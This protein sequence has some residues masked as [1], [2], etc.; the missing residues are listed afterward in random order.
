MRVTE[1][2]VESVLVPELERFAAELRREYPKVRIGVVSSPVGSKTDHQGHVVGVECL[3]E[4]RP[5]EQPDLLVLEI[6]VRHLATHPEI[7]AADVVWGHPSGQCEASILKQ[8]TPLSDERLGELV[9]NLPTLYQALRVALERGT[10][11]S[12]AC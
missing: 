7:H 8:P 9:R 6:G 1:K 12:G 3:F 4:A 2:V 11:G 5:A 10:P